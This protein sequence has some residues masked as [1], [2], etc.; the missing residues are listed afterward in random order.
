MPIRDLETWMWAEACE[1]LD[2][3]DRLHRQFFRP[4]VMNARRPT[5]EPPVDVFETR[6]ECK[7][8]IA[9]PGVAPEQLIVML[10]GNHLMIEGQRHLYTSA[11]SQ[12]RR[13]EIPYG[14]FERRIELP[15]GHYEIDTRELIHG[16]LLISL[17][18]I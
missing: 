17:R 4:T 11:E 2:R 10:E 8:M 15:P 12:I 18:K 1:I 6:Y 13:L 14:R 9:L 5:W 3:A 16:C 7:I